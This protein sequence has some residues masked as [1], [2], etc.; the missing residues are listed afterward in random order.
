MKVQVKVLE[1]NDDIITLLEE[2]LTIN[3]SQKSVKTNDD[4]LVFLEKHGKFNL[5]TEEFDST[6][7]RLEKWA[8][9]NK[10]I[11]LLTSSA[12]FCVCISSLPFYFN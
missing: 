6:L 3:N 9:A 4:I 10:K 2:W 7:L 1:K 11:I 8:K 5:D 12:I